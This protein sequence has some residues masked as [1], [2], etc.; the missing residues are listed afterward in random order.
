ML[1]QPV[2][3]KGRGGADSSWEACRPQACGQEGFTK[4]VHRGPSAAGPAGARPPLGPVTPAVLLPQDWR[5]MWRGAA[6]EARPNG[7][8]R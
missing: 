7:W 8:G 5:A 6:G 2:P 3:L 4:W 1:P